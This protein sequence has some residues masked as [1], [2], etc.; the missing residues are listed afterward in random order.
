M[1]KYFAAVVVVFLFSAC[2]TNSTN[3]TASEPTAAAKKENTVK[4]AELATN[5]DF[6]CD[7]ELTEPLGDTT[8]YNGKM[9]GFC[10]ENCKAEFLKDPAKYV[11]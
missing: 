10:H 2:N 8:M 4:V 3:Q 11:K 6:V 9:Y 7:M 1:K 5:K